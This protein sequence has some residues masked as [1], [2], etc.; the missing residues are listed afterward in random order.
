[1]NESFGAGCVGRGKG[2]LA[3]FS[4]LVGVVVVDVERCVHPDPGVAVGVVVPAVEG[5]AE[6]A[7]VLQGPEPVG[8]SGR[9]FNVLNCASENG[10]SF[11]QCGREWDLVTPRSASRNATG[12]EAIEE[13][14]SAWMVS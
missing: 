5:G 9:Y 7:G 13:P 12:L 2:R 6:R 8:K 14:R 3:G 4:D 10:L 11:E 1:M